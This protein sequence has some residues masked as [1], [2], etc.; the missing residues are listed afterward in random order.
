MDNGPSSDCSLSLSSSFPLL[1]AVMTLLVLRIVVMSCRPRQCC[2]SDRK[3]SAR[4]GD[5]WTWLRT[6]QATPWIQRAWAR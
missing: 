5:V 6:K 1:A 3:D 4:N 2:T